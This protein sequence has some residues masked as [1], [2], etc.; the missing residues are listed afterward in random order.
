MTVNIF[1]SFYVWEIGRNISKYVQKKHKCLITASKSL[2]NKKKKSLLW[3]NYKSAL[4]VL[5]I[6]ILMWSIIAKPK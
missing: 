1:F 2:V 6:A 5:F 3:I 4:L